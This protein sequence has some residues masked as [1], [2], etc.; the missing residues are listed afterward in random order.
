MLKKFVVATV[1]LAVLLVAGS[2]AYADSATTALTA[3]KKRVTARIDLRLAALHRFGTTLS[4]ADKVQPAHRAT[5]NNLISEQ[6]A[7]LQALRAKVAGEKSTDAVKADATSMVDD[8]RVFLLTG[9]KVRL[10]AAIDTELAVAAALG[11]KADTVAKSLSGQVD[12]LLAI[13]PGPDRDAIVAG[14]KPVRQAAH[15]AQTQLKS[16]I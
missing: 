6:T 4:N 10:T 16:L 11:D 3:G 7:E 2:P 8:F 9:P 12:T 15:T 13:R 5:L 14:L 1:A